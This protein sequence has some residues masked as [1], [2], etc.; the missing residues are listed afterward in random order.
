MNCG[1]SLC[2]LAYL[3]V[4]DVFSD[5]GCRLGRRAV[6]IRGGAQPTDLSMLYSITRYSPAGSSQTALDS[7]TFLN[8]SHGTCTG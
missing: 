4:M 6:D 7:F 2:N 1:S 8:D 5:L 3:V